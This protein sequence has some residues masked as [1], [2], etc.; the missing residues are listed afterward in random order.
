M[1]NSTDKESISFKMAP[2]K[3]AN[4]LT[5]K[6]LIG[7]IARLHHKETMVLLHLVSNP[8]EID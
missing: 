8:Y 4:G 6:G 3:L 1:A 2:S 7:L 5:A